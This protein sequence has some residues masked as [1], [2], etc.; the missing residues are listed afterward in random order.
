MAPKIVEKIPKHKKHA[1][2]VVR[3]KKVNSQEND[4]RP[5]AK[6]PCKV[7]ISETYSLLNSVKTESVTCLFLGN[8]S[9]LS[10]RNGQLEGLPP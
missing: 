5:H 9:E 1:L 2:F 3:S 4:S 10:L 7:I 6:F 8:M